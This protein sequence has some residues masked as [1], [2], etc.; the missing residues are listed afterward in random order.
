M[1]IYNWSCTVCV[2]PGKCRVGFLENLP[3]HR[4]PKMRMMKINMREGGD[5]K[6]QRRGE[7]AKERGR[8]SGEGKV[9]RNGEGTEEREGTAENWEVG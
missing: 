1:N 5:G 8:Y 9:Q 4:Q 3:N 7:G 6:V 2:W